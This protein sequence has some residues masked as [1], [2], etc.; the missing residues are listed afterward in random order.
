MKIK[1]KQS[2]VVLCCLL[3][4]GC[5]TTKPVPTTI[6]INDP[7][8]QELNSIADK[9][10]TTQEQL[11]SMQ[12]AVQMS[13]LSATGLKQAKTADTATPIGWGKKISLTY[14]GSYATLFQSLC[15]Q[16]GYTYYGLN[17]DSNP[18]IVTVDAVNQPLI[19]YLRAATAQLPDAYSVR[20]YPEN[21]TVVV[22]HE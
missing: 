22:H 21:K 9:A 7:A 18:P 16:A 14:T 1:L 15:Q 2:V 10:V 20:L 8:M 4:I 12:S 13:Q 6:T 11:A 5:A 17:I 3:M 19:H